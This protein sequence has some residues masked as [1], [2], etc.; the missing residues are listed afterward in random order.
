MKSKQS[1]INGARM[2]HEA[3]RLAMWAVIVVFAIILVVAFLYR[4]Q[5][6]EI[7]F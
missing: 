6:P 1:K 2:D 3:N 7:H 4:H 5:L